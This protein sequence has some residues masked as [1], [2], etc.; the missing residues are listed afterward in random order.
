MKRNKKPAR[1]SK[2]KASPTQKTFH[3]DINPGDVLLNQFEAKDTQ[4]FH[5]GNWKAKTPHT[6]V[7]LKKV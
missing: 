7:V 3:V 1:P 4:Y 6:L 2:H 5:L